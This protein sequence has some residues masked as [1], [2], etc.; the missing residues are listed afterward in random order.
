MVDRQLR[1]RGITDPR[2]LAAMEAIPRE[3]FIPESRR[4][5][6]YADAAIGID[7][8]QTISQPFIVAWMTELLGTA[9]GDRVLEIGTGSGYQAAVLA[10]LSCQVRSIER[11]PELA[12]SAR[13]RLA[14]LGYG[15]RVE[16]AVADGTLGDPSGAPYPRILV[17]AAAPSI[18]PAL[19][20]QLDPDGGRLVIPIGSLEQQELVVVDRHGDAWSERPAGGCVF[21][22]LVGEEGWA[23]GTT[24]RTGWEL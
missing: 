6:A 16:I 5:L 23:V 12:T 20:E 13:E 18:P 15:D 4:D 19:R 3:V 10:E 24:P 8:G 17:T 9:P 7:A 1:G 2:V 14:A 21:V 11:L 22:P